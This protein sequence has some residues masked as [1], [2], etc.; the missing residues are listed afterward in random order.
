MLP[1]A[2]VPGVEPVPVLEPVPG[3]SPTDEILVVMVTGNGYGE[4]R[5]QK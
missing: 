4:L 2:E 3:L 1:P 5:Y